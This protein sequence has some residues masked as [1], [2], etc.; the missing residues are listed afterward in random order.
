LR[1]L[2]APGF[3]ILVALLLSTA[4]L[5]IN[6][7]SDNYMLTQG[8]YYYYVF[9]PDISVKVEIVNETT[10][11]STWYLRLDDDIDVMEFN[12]SLIRVEYYYINGSYFSISYSVL[13]LNQD[14]W[15]WTH[16]SGIL[17]AYN[18]SFDDALQLALTYLDDPSRLNQTLVDTVY[19]VFFPYYPFMYDVGKLHYSLDELKSMIQ[20]VGYSKSEDDKAIYVNL[21]VIL[22]DYKAN[23][24]TTYKLYR[25]VSKDT[26]FILENYQGRYEG[27]ES[28]IPVKLVSTND[29][30]LQWWAPDNPGII[31]SP[32]T[33]TTTE[34][35]TDTS[36]PTTVPETPPSTTSPSTQIEEGGTTTPMEPGTQSQ[37]GQAGSN[38]NVVTVVAAVAIVVALAVAL[39]M[40]LGRRR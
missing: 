16:P 18:M 7:D 14:I 29:P 20:V 9:D 4:L 34:P 15:A 2:I 12:Q 35:V 22:N 13:E 40:L 31:P 25:V 33:T 23:K 21:T 39:Y 32:K 38:S 10:Y 8:Y 26:G 3:L 11:K 6:G 24:T 27:L 19:G 28:R 30:R 37:P 5:T 17:V 36:I 1:H